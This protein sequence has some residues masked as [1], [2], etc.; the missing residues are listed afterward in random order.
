MENRAHPNLVLF[1]MHLQHKTQ[2]V[3]GLLHGMRKMR[4][5]TQEDNSKNCVMLT[6]PVFPQNTSIFWANVFIKYFL[7]E[8]RQFRQHD[9]WSM[10]EALSSIVPPSLPQC[11]FIWP[12]TWGE[13]KEVFGNCTKEMRFSIFSKLKRATIVCNDLYTYNFHLRITHS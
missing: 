5:I 13:K 4:T 8:E 6:L 12:P 1:Q 7:V 3:C 9:M 11:C 10:S 2:T